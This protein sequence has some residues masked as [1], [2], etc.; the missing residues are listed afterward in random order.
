[1]FTIEKE[2]LEHVSQSL[3][4]M[5]ETLKKQVESRNREI[6]RLRNLLTGGRPPQA[7]AKDCCFKNVGALAEDVE[8]LQKDKVQQQ[9][10]LEESIKSQ[11]EA[12]KRAMDLA[13]ENNNLK[14]NIKKLADTA[15]TVESQANLKLVER[16]NFITELKIK[17][18]ESKNKIR[19]LEYELSHARHTDDKDYEKI[20]IKNDLKQAKDEIDDLKNSIK[21]Y[22]QRDIEC[23]Q[24]ED[25]LMAENRNISEKY[26]KVKRELKILKE[27]YSENN[28]DYLY[29]KL[30]RNHDEKEY[31]TML[32]Y[33][34]E[35]NRLLSER[36]EYQRKYTKL[37][38]QQNQTGSIDEMKRDI[39]EKDREIRKLNLELES[40]RPRPELSNHSVQAAIKRVE[41]ER[42]IL[43][44]DRDTFEIE[45]E[46]MRDKIESLTKT[47]ILEQRQHDDLLE[48]LYD[49]INKLEIDKKKLSEKQVPTE[50]AINLLGNEIEELRREMRAKNEEIAQL[51]T[52]YQQL[53][54][55]QE[56]TERSLTEEQERLQIRNNEVGNMELKLNHLDSNREMTEQQV[57]TLRTDISKLKTNNA[58]LEREKDK[59]MVS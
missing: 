49:K 27:N 18:T 25:D 9:I 44:A 54:V 15:L 12:M 58:T 4:E 11:H 50:M 51:K 31:E 57:S 20:S 36:N 13:E 30:K 59:L 1:M 2:R 42:D 45:C 7:L 33:K 23:K 16:E 19:E 46:H 39:A 40:Y 52:R 29:E 14:Q 55:L 10:Q 32:D 38:E 41:R 35:I 48:T 47:R 22:K 34:E 28:K 56:R 24:R 5:N 37:I 43:K 53:R 21:K 26:L 3:Y 17:L 6:E 8:Q